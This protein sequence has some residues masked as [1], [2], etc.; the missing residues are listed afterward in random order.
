MIDPAALR[1]DLDATTAALARRG[2]PADEVQRLADLDAE[3]RQK[4]AA[5]DQA[6]ADQKTA[7]KAIG[8][9]SA[10]ERAAL[11]EEASRLK[12]AVAD[13]EAQLD[14]AGQAFEDAMIRL[15][16]LPHP[17]A[18]DGQEGDGVVCARWATSRRSTSRYATTSTC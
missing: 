2:I 10:D 6:R 14:A 12:Q 15:P 3:R 4:I 5:V 17:D 7:S 1:N 8:S 18:P 13:L 11:I 16:N 9:A